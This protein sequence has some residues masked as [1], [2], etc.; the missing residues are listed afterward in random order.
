MKQY[1]RPE[2]THRLLGESVPAGCDWLG[3]FSSGAAQSGKIHAAGV[4]SWF[5]F[6]R[7]NT[8]LVVCLVSIPVS[9]INFYNVTILKVIQDFCC[10][11]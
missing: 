10:L 9:F 4:M 7:L 3:R 8:Q 5:C 2:P 1:V 6:R 11:V